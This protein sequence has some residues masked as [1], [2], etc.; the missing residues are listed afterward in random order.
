[1]RA[2]I[3]EATK[4]LGYP[5]ESLFQDSKDLEKNGWKEGARVGNFQRNILLKPQNGAE[6]KDLLGLDFRDTSGGTKGRTSLKLVQTWCIGNIV[7][8]ILL[9]SFVLVVHLLTDSQNFSQGKYF[10]YFD[11]SKG[12]IGAYDSKSPRAY[13]KGCPDLHHWSDVTFLIMKRINV[14][15][16]PEHIL[17]MLVKNDEALIALDKVCRM[18]TE[19]PVIALNSNKSTSDLWEPPLWPGLS[20]TMD[21]AQAKLLLATPNG[22]G[23]AW[24]LVQHKKDFGVLEVKKVTI[25]K[26]AFDGSPLMLFDIGKI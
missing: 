5:S 6:D 10:S 23:V 25:F 17:R 12:F 19:G 1:M 14:N 7:S 8:A 9:V 11:S 2:S 3:V 16:V 22:K 13:G 20:Y 24:L 18:E 15:F 21:S 4:L 26:A